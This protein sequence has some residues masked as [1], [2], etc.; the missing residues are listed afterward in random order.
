MQNA[1]L[2]FE[3][4]FGRPKA[5][6]EFNIMRETYERYRLVLVT[7]VCSACMCSGFSL[8]DCVCLDCE[9]AVVVLLC[10]RCHAFKSCFKPDRTAAATA[11]SAAA[12]VTAAA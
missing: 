10:E 8:G 6:W 5:D 3:K 4:S 11:V 12:D 9:S 7:C 2:K 1:L